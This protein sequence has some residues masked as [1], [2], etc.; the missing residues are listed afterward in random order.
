LYEIVFMK[1]LLFVFALLLPMSV[2]AQKYVFKV[3]YIAV[4]TK[5]VWAEW[6]SVKEANELIIIDKTNKKFTLPGDNRSI[7]D[8]LYI[9]ELKQDKDNKGSYKFLDLSCIV[10]ENGGLVSVKWKTYY[11]DDENV[12]TLLFTGGNGYA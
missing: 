1:K 9:S 5:T 11:K 2:N 10:P 6:M 7:M 4:S 12:F 3:N 8:I